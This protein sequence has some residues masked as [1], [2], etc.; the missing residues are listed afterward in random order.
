MKRV[1]DLIVASVGLV[2]LAPLWLMTAAV[3]AVTDGRPILFLQT[4]IG[5]HRSQFKIVKFRTM[6]AATVDHATD[7]GSSARVTRVGGVLRR[8]KLDE[9]PQLWNVVRGEMSMVGPRPELPEWVE[10]YPVEFD[11]VLSDRPGVTDPASLEFRNEEL[12][13]AETDDPHATYRD[14]I[15]PR[16]LQLYLEYQ[17]RR[18]LASD[19]VV[20]CRTV[21]AVVVRR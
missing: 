12:L 14:V 9:I 20:L 19:L 13:L 7:L 5:R 6:I 4:R 10:V 11:L 8:W 15:L 18:N 2:V 17:Q 21:A 3:I 16:K 1:L